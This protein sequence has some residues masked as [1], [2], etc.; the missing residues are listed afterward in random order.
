[1][2]EK[3]VCTTLS[4]WSRITFL[5]IYTSMYNFRPCFLFPTRLLSLY[6]T[7][8][9]VQ[10]Q[11]VIFCRTMNCSIGTTQLLIPWSQISF[12][13]HLAVKAFVFPPAFFFQKVK[14]IVMVKISYWGGFLT[15]NRKRK[16]NPVSVSIETTQNCL[17]FL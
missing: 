5:I 15:N 6:L 16:W 2:Q 8:S 17:H 9:N 7:Q 1:M 11:L 4:I 12:T 3:S 10:P 13:V 14:F